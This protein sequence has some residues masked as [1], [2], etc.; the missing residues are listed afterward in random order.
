LT[1]T[2]TMSDRHI[3][4]RQ[5]VDGRMY[6]S[7]IVQRCTITLPDWINT[8]KT[9]ELSQRRPRDAPNIWVALKSFESPHYAPDYSSRIVNVVMDLCSD[10]Y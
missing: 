7:Y 1:H 8:D 6:Y 4:G 2:M 3:G 10:R 9:A 5:T